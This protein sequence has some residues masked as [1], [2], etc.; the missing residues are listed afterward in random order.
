MPSEHVSIN[1]FT[2]FILAKYS[3]AHLHLYVYFVEFLFSAFYKTAKG[4]QFAKLFCLLLR[5]I[6]CFSKTMKFLKF[7]IAKERQSCV[8]GSQTCCFGWVQHMWWGHCHLPNTTVPFQCL[9]QCP[10]KVSLCL[11]LLALQYLEYPFSL[12]PPAPLYLKQFYLQCFVSTLL[13][14]ISPTKS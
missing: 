12:C 7:F 9:Y 4:L 1:L 13:P 8:Q 3:W 5:S 10:V 14:L 11:D 6:F 2:P